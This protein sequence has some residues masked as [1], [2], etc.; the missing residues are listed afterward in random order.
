[1]LP[2][3]IRFPYEYDIAY[4]QV[5]GDAR[6]YTHGCPAPRPIHYAMSDME[7]QRKLQEYQLEKMIAERKRKLDEI[8]DK[9]LFLHKYPFFPRAR[10]GYVPSNPVSNG[11]RPFQTSQEGTPL[12]AHGSLATFP[13]HALRGG[14]LTDYKYARFI[15]DR[16]GKQLAQMT[17]PLY[18]PP[19]PAVLTVEEKQR[20]DLAL[21]LKEVLGSLSDGSYTESTFIE[22]RKLTGQLITTLPLVESVEEI[23]EIIKAIDEAFEESGVVNNPSATRQGIRQIQTELDRNA[24]VLDKLSGLLVRVRRMLVAY[25]QRL[26]VGTMTLKARQTLVR[27]IAEQ[28]GL[29]RLADKT[30]REIPEEQLDRPAQSDQAPPPPPPPS[31]DEDEARDEYEIERLF[32]NLNE[33][34]NWTTQTGEEVE[35]SPTQQKVLLRGVVSQMNPDT[36]AS[37]GSIRRDLVPA[38]I[39][40]L[41]LLEPRLETN[42]IIQSYEFAPQMIEEYEF[43]LNEAQQQRADAAQASSIGAVGTTFPEPVAKAIAEAGEAA[44]TGSPGAAGAPAVPPRQQS[45]ARTTSAP[46]LAPERAVPPVTSAPTVARTAQP[47]V[48]RQPAPAVSYRFERT[49]VGRDHSGNTRTVPVPATKAEL[50]KATRAELEG[51]VQLATRSNYDFAGRSDLQLRNEIIRRFPTQFGINID[52]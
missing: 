11:N 33:R 17:D 1:M 24:A 50:R 28:I 35:L 48:A 8:R 10:E 4:R 26:G 21:M 19:Q 9:E 15:L 29:F 38:L 51:L 34:L 52:T 2:T 3:Q 16:R 43:Q 44:P 30:P 36:I 40:E 32:A 23:A 22:A 39:V 42:Q 20:L 13:H 27:S 7:S 18:T 6:R 45:T 5:Y 14:V 31:D 49:V 12:I 25:V 46:Q 37:V 41:L 47:E